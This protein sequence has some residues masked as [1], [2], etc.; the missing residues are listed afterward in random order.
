VR[1]RSYSG[2]AGKSS[3]SRSAGIQL[4]LRCELAR[5]VKRF[6]VF[7]CLDDCVQQAAQSAGFGAD[8][9]KTA[10]L[11]M[12]LARS[13][14]TWAPFY[15]VGEHPNSRTQTSKLQNPNYAKLATQKAE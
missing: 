2:A 11:V 3:I 8:K 10:I 5:Y 15:I 6:L 4:A 9:H 14:N 13:I 1:W 7:G 12:I